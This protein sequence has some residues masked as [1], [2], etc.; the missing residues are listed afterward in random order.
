MVDAAETATSLTS[1]LEKAEFLADRTLV[2][3]SIKNL[4]V[5]GEAAAHIPRRDHPAVA[6]RTVTNVARHAQPH[7]PRV[8]RCEP[9]EHVWGTINDDLPVVLAELHQLVERQGFEQD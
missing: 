9:G 2:D 5:L 8:L 3:A 6:R 1:G 7:H 4:S